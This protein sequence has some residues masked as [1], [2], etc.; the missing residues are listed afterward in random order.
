VSDQQE[1]KRKVA[2]TKRVRGK[3]GEEPDGKEPKDRQYAVWIL[4]NGNKSVHS[5]VCEE[6]REPGSHNK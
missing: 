1:R 2:A 6:R 3:E 4:E 5:A